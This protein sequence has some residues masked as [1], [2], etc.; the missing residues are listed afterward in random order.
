MTSSKRILMTNDFFERPFVILNYPL[1]IG[2]MQ[3]F[4]K[5]VSSYF[6]YPPKQR[7]SSEANSSASVE[8]SPGTTRRQ[9]QRPSYRLLYHR[10]KSD[11][12]E[13]HKRKHVAR[14]DEDGATQSSRTQ[15]S[16]TSSF[17]E[18]SSFKLGKSDGNKVDLTPDQITLPPSGKSS[19]GLGLHSVKEHQASTSFRSRLG[20][21]RGRAPS[22]S[23]WLGTRHSSSEMAR[24]ASS[25]H[26]EPPTPA[27]DILLV[28]TDQTPLRPPLFKSAAADKHS[29]PSSIKVETEFQQRNQTLRK[30][31]S[32]AEARPSPSS[33]RSS[34]NPKHVFSL[35]FVHIRRSGL[36]K[37]P[38]MP[39]T[40]QQPEPSPVSE[41][42]RLADHTSLLKRNYTSE[43]LQRV[44]AILQEMKP[45]S[46]TSLWPPQ[47][48]KPLRWRT[49]SDK[50]FMPREKRGIRTAQGI[51]SQFANPHREGAEFVSDVHS[52]TSSQR[53]LRMGAQPS[54]TPDERA[55]YKVKRSGSAETE[56][57][58]KVDISIRGGTSYL[59]SEARRIHTPPLPE[60]GLDGRWRGFFF[61][62]NAPR[63]T[64]S[65]RCS[66]RGGRL[67]T[68]EATPA[69]LGESRSRATTISKRNKS[70][71]KNILAGDWY[72]VKLAELDMGGVVDQVE[73]FQAKEGEKRVNCLE[74]L[75][76][77][78]RER[79]HPEFDWTIPEH[80]PSSPLCPRH[81]RYWR[82]VKGKGDQFRGC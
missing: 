44:S 24:R 73:K 60:E 20:H 41:D 56:E 45:S 77:I 43:A 63:R 26:T 17:H 11:Y 61:D 59:P 51:I 22:W 19:P 8:I 34:L 55:T 82:V 21:V 27:S 81:P 70:K 13:K 74:V 35:P 58:L 79:D 23:G 28:R 18:K 36:R 67:S 42:A 32:D 52:Y 30:E 57:F 39:S 46:Q 25:A 9:D 71:N 66:E 7:E 33:R 76:K 64:S 78:G 16:T 40:P 6:D 69:S 75:S 12:D 47:V 2:Q 10:S 72:E 38:V 54:N 1:P 65:L 31:H 80:L 68:G 15:D 29:E 5:D 53:N 14:I 48:I 50:S 37:L 49:L 4:R 3:P 62:Y